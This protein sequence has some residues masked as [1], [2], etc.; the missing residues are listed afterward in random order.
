MKHL[1]RGQLFLVSAGIGDPE[2]MTLRAVEVI[3]QADLILAMPFV[4]K[5]IASFL[6]HGGTVV[7]PGHGLFTELSRNHLV[8]VASVDAMEA[9][10]RHMVR[11]HI[12]CGK[13]VVVVEFGD[14]TLC[15]PQIGY[16]NEFWDLDPVLIRWYFQF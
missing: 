14:P 11:E 6:P 13:R 12:Q 16:L 3:R 8:D 9:R 1:I 5:Q 10:V 15:G 2:N 7:D 4:Q